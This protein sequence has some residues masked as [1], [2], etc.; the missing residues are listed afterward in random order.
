MARAGTL[1]LRLHTCRCQWADVHTRRAEHGRGFVS[2]RVHCRLRLAGHVRAPCPLCE[3]HRRFV[4]IPSYRSL[5]GIH[6]GTQLAQVLSQYSA[7]HTV[8]SMWVSCGVRR[9]GVSAALKE[10]HS[11]INGNDSPDL[12]HRGALRLV[13]GTFAGFSNLTSL[14]AG[15]AGCAVKRAT[16]PL[17]RSTIIHTGLDYLDLGVLDDIQGLETL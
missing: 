14:Y 16:H 9:V 13:P 15:C 3:P 8:N 5:Q 7:K 4:V 12:R 2:L 11:S 1:S 10:H 17:P 6:D